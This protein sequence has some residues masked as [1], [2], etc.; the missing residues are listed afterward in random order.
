MKTTNIAYFGFTDSTI[1]P[2]L[3][4]GYGTT[5]VSIK[6]NTGETKQAR[7]IDE[8]HREIPSYEFVRD[9]KKIAPLMK[10]VRDYLDGK[11]RSFDLTFDISWMTPFR[12]RVMEEC[13][14]VP[15]GQVATYADLAVRAGSPRAARAVGNSMRTNPIPIVI[16]CHRIIGS[17]G[18]LTGFG[19]GL[20]V[21]A[22]LLALEGAVLG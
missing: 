10:Q 7:A 5:L 17:N 19:G 4:A 6:F 13:Y 22:R 3:V 14:A 9:D 20:D 16:P 21:K 2:L 15:R 11:R 18:T 1:G 12:K 8:L